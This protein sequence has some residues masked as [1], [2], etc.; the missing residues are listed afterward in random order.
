M[1]LCI[2]TAFELLLF[3]P[4]LFTRCNRMIE[5]VQQL[6]FDLA[7]GEYDQLVAE[8]VSMTKSTVV[9]LMNYYKLNKRTQSL[10][11]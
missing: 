11:L 10:L 1:P 9:I 4:I 3:I 7:K 2:Q 6:G 8:A 5:G